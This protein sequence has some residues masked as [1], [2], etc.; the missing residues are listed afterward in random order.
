[1]LVGLFKLE[2]LLNLVLLYPELVVVIESLRPQQLRPLDLVDEL[3]AFHL[4]LFVFIF[5]NLHYSRVRVVQV[6]AQPVVDAFVSLL[7]VPISNDG[8]EGVLD[9]VVREPNPTV[10]HHRTTDDPDWRQIV[11]QI[12]ELVSV[13]HGP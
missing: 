3:D 5:T 12:L 8:Q 13:P 6:I 11:I 2:N 7:D 1:L 10:D 4:R 9:Q